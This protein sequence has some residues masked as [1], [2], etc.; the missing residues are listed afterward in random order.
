MDMDL[1]LP[2]YGKNC[3]KGCFFAMASLIT[4][5]QFRAPGETKLGWQCGSFLTSPSGSLSFDPEVCSTL[6]IFADI[7]DSCSSLPRVAMLVCIHEFLCVRHSLQVWEVSVGLPGGPQ[8]DEHL[9]LG[10]L[11]LTMYQE[12]HILRCECPEDRVQVVHSGHVSVGC[13]LPQ[14]L[15]ILTLTIQSVIMEQTVQEGVLV[16]GVTL[17]IVRPPSLQVL[18]LPL[19]HM[20]PHHVQHLHHQGSLHVAVH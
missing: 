7:R 15:F 1:M 17:Q 14:V 4:K 10:K 13:L 16:F 18:H 20:E 5:F 8:S 11:I 6:A 3:V 12:P 2:L 19:G 9:S